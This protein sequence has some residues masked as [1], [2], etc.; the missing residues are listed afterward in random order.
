M[1]MM[2]WLVTKSRYTGLLLVKFSSLV[3]KQLGRRARKRGWSIAMQPVFQINIPLYQLRFQ[4][5]IP[6]NRWYI[7]N[8]FQIWLTPVDYE[9]LAVGFEP[10]RNGEIFGMYDNV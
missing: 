6:S 8:I 1:V 4:V 9:E 5:N 3:N 2:R 10:I 7:A